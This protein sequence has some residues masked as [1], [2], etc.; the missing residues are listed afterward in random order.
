MAV[1]KPRDEQGRIIT[2]ISSN[3]MVVNVKHLLTEID[4][5]KWDCWK[6]EQ[7]YDLEPEPG[8]LQNCPHCGADPTPF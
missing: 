6:C 2:N 1:I 3:Q 7:V 4:Y 8:K 5:H